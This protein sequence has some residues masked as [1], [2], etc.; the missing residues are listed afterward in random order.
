LKATTTSTKILTATQIKHIYTK[1]V[2]T[3]TKTRACHTQFPRK[4]PVCT[5]HVSKASA[6]FTNSSATA[7]T[8]HSRHSRRVVDKA[9]LHFGRR[10]ATYEGING[11][12]I[13]K[14]RTLGISSIPCLIWPNLMPLDLC[15]TT[16]MERN[17]T[18]TVINTF[19]GPT[20]TVIDP[21]FTTTTKTL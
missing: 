2:V 1:V 12:E 4:D 8:V 17:F 6:L 13:L 19:T 21:F 10:D 15:T 14:K 3:K 18:S 16:V 7:V 11:R 5:I 9:A 20:S